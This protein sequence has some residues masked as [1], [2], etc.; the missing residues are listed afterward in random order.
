MA[1]ALEGLLAENAEAWRIFR[2]LATRLLVDL[3][4][5]NTALD[6]LTADLDV[7]QFEDLMQRLALIYDVLYPAPM[8]AK[9]S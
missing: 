1:R 7:E 9:E 2:L 6:R 8:P 4:A 5:G 3:G